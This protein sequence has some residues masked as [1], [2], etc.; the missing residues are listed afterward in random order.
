MF[1]IVL[2][3]P[4]YFNYTLG[5][6][7]CQNCADVPLSNKQTN[8]LKNNSEKILFS[9]SVCSYPKFLLENICESEITVL[10]H[11]IFCII[12]PGGNQHTIA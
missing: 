7:T 2:I 9:V 3:T 5:T 11:F 8:K 1:Q 6:N 10:P 4:L 12:L